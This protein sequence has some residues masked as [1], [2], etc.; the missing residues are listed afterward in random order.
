[1][2]QNI[3]NKNNIITEIIETISIGKQ[4]LQEASVSG[5]LFEKKG[6]SYRGLFKAPLGFQSVGLFPEA[7]RSLD[8]LKARFMQIDGDFCDPPDVEIDL[9]PAPSLQFFYPYRSSWIT[10]GAQ[11]L[12]RYDIS[13]ATDSFI[14]SLQDKKN[15]GFL[16]SINSSVRYFNIV[17]TS[18][19]VLAALALGKWDAAKKGADFLANVLE[20]QSAH[21]QRLY[22]TVD[23]HFKV[24]ENWPPDI[25]GYGFLEIGKPNQYS[26]VTGL[27]AAVLASC[28][29]IFGHQRHLQASKGYY[30]FTVDIHEDAFTNPACGKLMWSAALLYTITD[31]LKYLEQCD[32]ASKIICSIINKIPHMHIDTIY[33]DYTKQ[34]VPFTF[35]VA[36]EY[37]YWLTEVV[38]ELL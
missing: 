24:V 31:E 12:G 19:A 14:L 33:P 26:Y 6:L 38:K 16:A 29:R 35:E 15:G 30:D 4:W 9:H 32:F 36:F 5:G 27:A 3:V 25:S 20:I 11:R 18:Q 8:I 37:I 23:E 7:S 22:T 21:L 2:K 17:G 1:M 34:P 10:I 13:Y 28:Y